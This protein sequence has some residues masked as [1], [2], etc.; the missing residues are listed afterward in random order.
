LDCFFYEG[1]D[2]MFQVGLAILKITEK[3]VLQMTDPVK[4]MNVLRETPY[5]NL[6][7]KVRVF[8]LVHARFDLFFFFVFFVR[9]RLSMT[10]EV[11]KER[12][13]RKFATHRRLKR[14]EISTRRKRKKSA[15][16]F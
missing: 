16:Q 1:P 13:S 6:L 2:V 12:K 5:G 9:R 3:E 8:R 14:F 11:S 15:S 4:I 10:L 7:I